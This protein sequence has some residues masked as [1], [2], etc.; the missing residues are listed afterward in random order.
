AGR[1]ARLDMIQPLTLPAA[2]FVHADSVARQN[3]PK[4]KP[5]NERLR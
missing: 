3:A 2:Q 4:Q 5:L 1:C